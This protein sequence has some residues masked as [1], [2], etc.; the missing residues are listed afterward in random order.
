MADY[1]ERYEIREYLTE[2][3]RSPFAAWLGGLRDRRARA[4][5]DTRLVR[6]RLGNLGDYAA[7]GEGVHELRIFYGPGYRVYFGFES[8]TV[9]VLLGGGT[10]SSQRRDIATAK[11]YWNDYR[12]RDDYE[13]QTL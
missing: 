5:I 9:V 2:D 12:S 11:A 8:N 13:E 3:G 6:V 7:V 1:P 4:R 10:K